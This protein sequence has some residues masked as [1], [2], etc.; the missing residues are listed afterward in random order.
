MYEK[1][2][3]RKKGKKKVKKGKKERECIELT[4]FGL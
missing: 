1:K 2:K 3:E 4:W